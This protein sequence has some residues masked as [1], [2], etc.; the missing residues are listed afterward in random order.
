M[1]A[2]RRFKLTA[3][4][5]SC[6]FYKSNINPPDKRP[7]GENESTRNE[8]KQKIV[9]M[10]IP[11]N[12]NDAMTSHKLQ[13]VTKNLIVHNWTYTHGSVYT[14]LSRVRT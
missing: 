6:T 12:L 4:K 10:Q 3:K 1:I 2:S 11:V 5:L 9:L 7:K 13:G 14:V 8:K